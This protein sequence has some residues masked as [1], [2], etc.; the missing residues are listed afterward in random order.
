[1]QLNDGGN[2]VLAVCFPEKSCLAKEWHRMSNNALQTHDQSALKVFWKE[3][4]NRT[5]DP[6]PKA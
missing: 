6:Y 4:Y 3:K 5:T 1:M 2:Y